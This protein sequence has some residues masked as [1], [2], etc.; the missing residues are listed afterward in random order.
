MAS[1]TRILR[2]QQSLEKK[3]KGLGLRDV[4]RVGPVQD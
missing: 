1:R 3:M 4:V 2:V